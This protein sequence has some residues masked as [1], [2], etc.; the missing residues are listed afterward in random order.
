MY[1]IGPSKT[2]FIKDNLFE[3]SF[4]GDSEAKPKREHFDKLTTSRELHYLASIYNWDDGTEVL[5]WVINS[6]LCDKG[7]AL[8]IFWRSEPD[9]YT[10]FDNEEEAEYER[11]VYR[12]V[13]N[14]IRNIETNY[15]KRSRIRFNAKDPPYDTDY[16]DKRAKWEIPGFMKRSVF[17][18]PVFSIEDRLLL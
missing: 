7:T 3:V 8:L 15:Y 6:P 1:I 2:R 4:R 14:I 10:R 16:V 9:F 17:G 5:E 11:D 13:K 12:L 18:L